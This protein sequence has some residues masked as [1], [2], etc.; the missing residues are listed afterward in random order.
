MPYKPRKYKKRNYK[1]KKS[2]K[3]RS[4]KLTASSFAKLYNQNFTNINKHWNPAPFPTAMKIRST[5]NEK[6]YALATSGTGTS[7]GTPATLPIVNLNS[8]YDPFVIT[9]FGQESCRYH[10][11]FSRYYATYEVTYAVIKVNVRNTTETDSGLL[12][13][14]DLRVILGISDQEGQYPFGANQEEQVMFPGVQTGLLESDEASKYNRKTFYFKFNVAKWAKRANQAQTSIS[15]PTNNNPLNSPQLWV[16]IAN[17][18]YQSG[19]GLVNNARNNVKAII[20]M[21]AVYYIKY[22]DRND[23]VIMQGQ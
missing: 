21:E 22:T 10:A 13:Q 14:D 19:G 16:T 4:S 2:Y 18:R 6:G 11:I 9:G 15:A 23:N 17:D 12:F 5:W 7:I 1:K 3:K 20:D 8:A